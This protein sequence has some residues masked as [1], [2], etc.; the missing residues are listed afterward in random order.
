MIPVLKMEG[1]VWG[2]GGEARREQQEAWLLE[3]TFGYWLSLL[4]GKERGGMEGK[5]PVD[6]LA[7]PVVLV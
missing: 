7:C 1:G 3:S 4:L 2:G 5:E 6:W